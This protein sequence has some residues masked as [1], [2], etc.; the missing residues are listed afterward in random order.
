MSETK[1][2]EHVALMTRLNEQGVRAETTKQ[3]RKALADQYGVRIPVNQTPLNERES[4]TLNSAAKVW[5]IDYHALLIAANNGTLTTFRPP[6]RRG[7]RS[8]R[9]VTRKAMEEFIAQFEEWACASTSFAPPQRFS[10]SPVWLCYWPGPMR[11]RERRCSAACT[12]SPS[13]CCCRPPHT[14]KTKTK[15]TRKNRRETDLAKDPSISIIRGRLAADPE[16]RTTGN[17]IPVVNLRILSSGWEK[18]TAGNP[19]DVTPTS[20]QCEA[21][22]EL[23]EHIVTS[24]RKG[25]QVLATVRPQTNR[26]EKRDGGTGWS[27]RW[28]IED[29]GPS[30]QRATTAITRIQR[31]RHAQPQP[32]QDGYYEPPSTA[33]DPWTN[34]GAS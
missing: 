28:V 1:I 5:N 26:F 25:D 7:T 12:A 15:K 30:L 13:A 17:G 22:R 19:V 23:A 6:S 4:W 20:W 34:Q 10:R 8:W 24:L 21:W 27:T 31:D 18:D 11:A 33:N 3:A 29:I 32:P 16:Y 2:L 14:R 9:R